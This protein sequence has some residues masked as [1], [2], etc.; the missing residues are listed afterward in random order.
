MKL[1]NSLL[2][3]ALLGVSMSC[4]H[5]DKDV[6]AGPKDVPLHVRLSS[7]DTG[8][9]EVDPVMKSKLGR[10]ADVKNYGINVFGLTDSSNNY[11]RYKEPEDAR[12]IYRLYLTPRTVLP[13]S[14]AESVFL[15]EET[16]HREPHPSPVIL[17]SSL[18]DL[19]DE[20]EFYENEGLDTM[21]RSIVNFSDLAGCDLTPDFINSAWAYQVRTLF[22]EDW[23]ITFDSWHPKKSISHAIHEPAAMVMGYAGAIEYFRHTHGESSAEYLVAVKK[24]EDISAEA[25]V[26]TDAYEILKTIYDST[27]SEDAKVKISEETF[28]YMEREG[29]DHNNA[30][31]MDRIIYM[32][33]L[34]LMT[35]VHA[36]A[37]SVTEFVNVMR[38]CPID[39][40][41]SAVEY[42]VKYLAG[43]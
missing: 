20:E 31:L 11:L 13:E 30:T 8:D 9:I 3:S 36:R 32:K 42:L 25:D 7:F 4:A 21:N 18:D 33:Y 27:I 40:E 16:E 39:D 2:F 5:S 14:I 1:I 29:Y 24:Y 41:D 28:A 15:A 22:H 23:H 6:E 38:D 43:A 19:L 10:I 34:P 35:L 26:I 37:G 17:K 12:M